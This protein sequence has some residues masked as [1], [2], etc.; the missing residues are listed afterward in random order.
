MDTVNEVAVTIKFNAGVYPNWPNIV[1]R[2]HK[3]HTTLTDKQIRTI[4]Y[5]EA[6]HM[7]Y[8][9]KCQ[10]GEEKK[11]NTINSTFIVSGSTASKAYATYTWHPNGNISCTRWGLV[12][13]YHV[14]V[15]GNYDIWQSD[16][17]T[18][19]SLK[20]GEILEGREVH[21]DMYESTYTHRHNDG[22]TF[23]MAFLDGVCDGINLTHD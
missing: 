23:Y 13:T 11:R 6:L 10:A 16:D 12:N 7:I 18:I 17:G 20:N 3:Y 15:V 1:C 21:Q 4:L 5:M 14:E 9:S 19:I 2:A 22:R 8:S